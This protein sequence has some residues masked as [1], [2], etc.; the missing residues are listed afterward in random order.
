LSIFLGK[1]SV[2]N[3]L[4]FITIL[5]VDPYYLDMFQKTLNIHPKG[6]C[7]T[8]QFL[9]DTATIY[10]SVIIW[11]INILSQYKYQVHLLDSLESEE[12]MR[13][14]LIVSMIAILSC[15]CPLSCSDDDGSNTNNNP[16]LEDYYPLNVGNM[17]TYS[18][19]ALM[20]TATLT[21]V[22]KNTTRMQGIPTWIVEWTNLAMQP[23]SS[24]TTY[25][26]HD[27]STIVIVAVSD[28][29]SFMGIP[30]MFTNM[31][32]ES[33]MTYLDV[34]FPLLWVELPLSTG[35]TWTACDV[36][37]PD[38]SDILNTTQI[39]GKAL[40]KDHQSFI[41]ADVDT[42]ID[43]CH[44]VEITF[45]IPLPQIEEDTVTVGDSVVITRDTI[46]VPSEIFVMQTWFADG[47]GL[48]AQKYSFNPESLGIP[49]FT[50]AMG[51][52]NDVL[53][54]Y[55]LKNEDE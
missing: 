46:S 34:I 41:I 9:Q 5:G 1:K 22:V 20:S 23:T 40:V 49:G 8:N 55:I 3:L 36:T 18:S 43:S 28:V 53:T 50:T 37:I 19:T 12:N 26:F 52:R 54:D 11:L 10:R 21:A 35:R 39:T 32:P 27:D 16:P 17:W 30:E 2:K 24:D 31:I 4:F 38:P 13:K 42:I 51:I 25:I 48:I 14:I 47:I 33:I 15:L 29:I 6:G 7:L 44:E 45:T